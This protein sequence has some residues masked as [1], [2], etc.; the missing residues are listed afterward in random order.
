MN[1]VAYE[2]YLRNKK[3]FQFFDYHEG[4]KVCFID[5]TKTTYMGKPLNTLSLFHRKKFE[6]AL[7]FRDTTVRKFI[8]K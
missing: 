7:F 3:H 8:Y 6:N 2:E 5:T 1:L 4:G